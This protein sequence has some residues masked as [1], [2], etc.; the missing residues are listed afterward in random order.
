MIVFPILEILQ[1]FLMVICLLLKANVIIGFHPIPVFDKENQPLYPIPNEEWEIKQL[2]LLCRMNPFVVIFNRIQCSFSKDETKQTDGKE[3]LA[4]QIFANQMYFHVLVYDG[5]K[6][7]PFP[8]KRML[9]E[10]NIYE[11]GLIFRCFTPKGD[12]K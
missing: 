6:V 10:Q 1:V 4:Q 2:P 11:D 5:S 3:V 8:S 9:S 12:R 7:T